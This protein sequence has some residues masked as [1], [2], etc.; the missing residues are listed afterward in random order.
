[1]DVEELIKK[2]QKERSALDEIIGSLEAMRSSVM[3]AQ[4]A[5]AKKRRGRRSMSIEERQVVSERIKKYWATMSMEERRV[6]AERMKKYWARRRQAKLARDR[7]R[8]D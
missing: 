5:A 8:G 3:E 2:L 6:I 7:R 1:M 4:A